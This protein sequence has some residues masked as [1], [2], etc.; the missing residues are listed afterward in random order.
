MIVTIVHK[1]GLLWINIKNNLKKNIVRTHLTHSLA[2]ILSDDWVVLLTSVGGPLVWMCLQRCPVT[3]IFLPVWR[4]YMITFLFFSRLFPPALPLVTPR[5]LLA[6]TVCTAGLTDRCF[7]LWDY[8]L[9]SDDKENHGDSF[10]PQYLQVRD[11]SP[12]HLNSHPQILFLH[13][14]D[15]KEGY[16]QLKYAMSASS[17][18]ILLVSLYQTAPVQSLSMEGREIWGKFV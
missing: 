4:G 12:E 11:D 1:V 8:L 2:K 10:Y 6:N 18:F 9:P 14:C 17:H 15:T 7:A 3:L 16:G 5:L 13:L